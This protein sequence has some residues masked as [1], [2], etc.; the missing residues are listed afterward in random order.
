M[1]KCNKCLT[2]KEPTEFYGV[3][4]ECKSCTKKRVRLREAELKQSPEWVKKEKDRHRE[5]YHRLGYKDI[6][7]PSP[8][9]KKVIMDRYK[10]KFPEKR[11]AHLAAQRLTPIT[12]G[13]ELHHWSYNEEHY[14]DV[15]E[16][17]VLEHNK[18]HRYIVYDQERMM[19][20]RSDN[21]ELLDTKESHT[22]YIN[23]LTNKN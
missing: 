9:Q 22:A 7:K 3:Q 21:N 4:G 12:P 5:K 17:S 1:K 13:N 23:S 15:I 16:L 20:R 19:Y 14:K 18:A 10:A 11:K 2:E 8:E 6:H